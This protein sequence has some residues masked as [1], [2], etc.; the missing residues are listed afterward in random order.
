M[1]GDVI[2]ISQDP[3]LAARVDGSQVRLHRTAFFDDDVSLIMPQAPD[4]T[5]DAASATGATV[6]PPSFDTTVTTNITDLT[7]FD[8]CGTAA[9]LSL[10]S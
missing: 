6:N 8:R 7:N 2:E 5:P 9:S 1:N 3:S 4:S 10:D